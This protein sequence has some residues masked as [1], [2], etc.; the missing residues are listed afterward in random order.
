MEEFLGKGVSGTVL[1]AKVRDVNFD[2]AIKIINQGNKNIQA[3]IEKEIEVLKKCKHTNIVAYYGTKIQKDQIWIIMDYCG[4]GSVK[5]II[6]ISQDTL[7]EKQAQYVLKGTMKGLICLHS[8]SILHLDI[9]SANILMTENGEVKLADFGVSTQLSHAF[10]TATQYVGSPLFMSPEVIRRDVY[11]HKTDIWSLG[12]TAIEMVEGDPPNTDID[13]LEKLPLLAERPPPTFR[14]QKIWSEMFKDFVARMLI[15]DQ[16][17]RPS[18]VDLDLHPFLQVVAGK[19]VMNELLD[20]VR[21]LILS[22]RKKITGSF[23]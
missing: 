9:K 4:V 20:S 23:F 13:S 15:K 1:R 12:I 7:T 22:K 2:V 5:D 6:K 21:D 10:L 18:A 19:E 16:N 8:N 11:N 17:E 3:E 14:N